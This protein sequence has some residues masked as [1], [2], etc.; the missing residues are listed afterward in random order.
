MYSP[1]NLNLL[2]ATTPRLDFSE[3]NRTEVGSNDSYMTDTTMPRAEVVFVP[4]SFL[5]IVWILLFI[6]QVNFWKSVR[7][8]IATVKCIHQVP[9]YNCQF[10]KNNPYLKCAVQPSKVLSSDAMECPD[11]CPHPQENKVSNS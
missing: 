8:R 9:C 6:R 7:N 10:F 5:L 3:A 4:L 2:S 1:Q 11:Y